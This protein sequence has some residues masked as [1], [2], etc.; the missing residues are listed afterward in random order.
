MTRFID[1]SQLAV[2]ARCHADV[3]V[4]IHDAQQRTDADD[5]RAADQQRNA[6]RDS[7]SQALDPKKLEMHFAAP[8]AGVA[9]ADPGS[10]TAAAKCVV[11]N[12]RMLSSFCSY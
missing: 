7:R 11:R 5:Q 3:L 9:D 10:P 4:Q 1:R 6:K 2:S 12:V 8:V